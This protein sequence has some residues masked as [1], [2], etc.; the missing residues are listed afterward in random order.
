MSDFMSITFDSNGQEVDT[1]IEGALVETKEQHAART[2][3]GVEYGATVRDVNAENLHAQQT[4]AQVNNPHQAQMNE[5]RLEHTISQYNELVQIEEQLK[6]SGRSLTQA[7]IERKGHLYR[8]V[9]IQAAG[10]PGALEALGIVI[11]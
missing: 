5:E 4:F 3:A 10:V 6:L 1:S 11:E 7:Q 8:D 2:S 9:S